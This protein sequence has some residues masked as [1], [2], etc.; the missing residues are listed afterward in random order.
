MGRS[1]Q[2]LK[3]DLEYAVDQGARL[4]KSGQPATPADIAYKQL[5]RED[6]EYLP[7]FVVMDEG[8]TITEIWYGEVFR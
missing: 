6:S 5:I 1:T 3:V 7:D 2:K 4:Y 8:G